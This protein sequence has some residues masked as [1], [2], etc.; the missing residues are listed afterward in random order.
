MLAF[1]S[2]SY[3]ES[4]KNP[5]AAVARHFTVGDA[6]AKE[7][8][9]NAPHL[10]YSRPKGTYAGADTE[11]LMIDFYLLNTGLA[12]DGNRVRATINGTELVFSEWY[13]YV[14]EGLPLG[15]VEIT[16]EL[17]DGDGNPVPG[18]FNSVTRTVTLEGGDEGNEA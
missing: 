18:P 13:P 6:E 5:G 14:V 8:D 9:L 11:R 10:F 4:L 16:L 17:I 12:P 1:L 2:R 3:H 15:E 7:V